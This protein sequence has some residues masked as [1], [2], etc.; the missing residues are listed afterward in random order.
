MPRRARRRGSAEK[1]SEGVK[2]WEGRVMTLGIMKRVCVWGGVG[3]GGGS[4][5]GLG[6][7][8]GLAVSG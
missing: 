1:F 8:L 6:L 4:G 7:G 3:W 2:E 5:L